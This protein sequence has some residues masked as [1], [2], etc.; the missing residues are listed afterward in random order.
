MIKQCTNCIHWD[1]DHYDNDIGFCHIE[2]IPKS[3]S[4]TCDYWEGDVE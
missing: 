3:K 1:K 4:E 2:M